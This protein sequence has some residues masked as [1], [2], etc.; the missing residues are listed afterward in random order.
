MM[1]GSV[2]IPVATIPVAMIPVA[3]F[4]VVMSGV[5]LNI[6]TMSLDRYPPPSAALLTL[7]EVCNYVFSVAFSIEM[8]IILVARGPWR[9]WTDMV[10]AFDGV[11]VIASWV[12]I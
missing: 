12:E 9:Y 1:H 3:T 7:L 11:I 10:T 2:E 5:I 8:V 4:P 6:V